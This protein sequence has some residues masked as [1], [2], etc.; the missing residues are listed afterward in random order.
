M[1]AEGAERATF[2]FGQGG[3]KG[4]KGGGARGD[5]REGGQEEGE[6]KRRQDGS[7]KK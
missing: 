7:L 2:R 1:E 4:E 5:R 6:T 3:E